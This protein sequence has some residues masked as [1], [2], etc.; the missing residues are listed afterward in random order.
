VLQRQTVMILGAPRELVLLRLP[1]SDG[2][3]SYAA[4]IAP[5]AAASSAVLLTLP[6]EGI[7]WTGEAVDQ[8]WRRSCAQPVCALPD[9]DSPG[10][11]SDPGVIAYKY[12]SP[13]AFAEA[14]TVHVANGAG[15]LGVFGR[16]YA[17]G[18]WYSYVRAM[19]AGLRFLQS[20]STVDPTRV[21][22]SGGSFGGFLSFYAA[23]FAPE[24]IAPRAVVSFF[25]PVDLREQVRFSQVI[26]PAMARTPERRAM[27]ATFIA[28]YLRRAVPDVGPIEAADY[29]CF[30]PEYIVPK[31]RGEVFVAWDDWDMLV[32]PSVS[33]SLVRQLG[34][35]GHAHPYRHATPP[36]FEALPLDHGPFDR[37]GGADAPFSSFEM[38][39]YAFVHL[40][41][42]DGPVL[43]PIHAPTLDA[44]LT[45]W[46][47]E[48]RAGQ[49]EPAYA[50][51]LAELADDRVMLFN[52]QTGAQTAAAPYLSEAI[53]RVWGVTIPADTLQSQLRAQGLPP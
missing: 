40:R 17:G 8:R 9:V 43:V 4:W 3:A 13:A 18:S 15:V 1:T 19:V 10:A 27:F 20:Q 46:H 25:P 31:V 33:E 49:R 34:P 38:F 7:D 12:L 16:F 30:A 37:V 21:A 53:A 2:R 47:D 11:P 51:R 6:Y 52:L 35:R 29:R 41:I 45:R 5:R 28:P 44:L 14:A 22:I 48:Q 39:S 50:Q 42:S 23:A 36:D 24:G 32:P 26:A